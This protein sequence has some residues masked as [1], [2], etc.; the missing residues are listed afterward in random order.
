MNRL[1]KNELA[2]LKENKHYWKVEKVALEVGIKPE[3]ALKFIDYYVQLP[4]SDVFAVE[5]AAK[6]S[7]ISLEK[8]LEFKTAYYLF[9]NYK[10]L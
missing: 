8:A 4:I 5:K 6:Q 7:D 10:Y 1:N 9:G 3:Q 2:N